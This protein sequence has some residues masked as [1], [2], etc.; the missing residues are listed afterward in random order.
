MKILICGS[1]GWTDKKLIYD[2]LQE[3]WEDNRPDKWRDHI[4]I[5][6][7]YRGADKL[8]GQAAN[9]LGIGEVRVSAQWENYGKRAGPYRNWWMAQLAPDVV[10]AFSDSW[11]KSVG[12]TNMM[13]V[14]EG[15]GIPVKMFSSD[16]V[17]SDVS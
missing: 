9:D 2:L 17:L 1:R 12:T 8:A 13:G 10:W 15:L 6:G 11:S 3:M 7:D 16:A 5:H 4:V 14:A